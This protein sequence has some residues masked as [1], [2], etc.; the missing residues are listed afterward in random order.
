MTYFLYWIGIFILAFSICAIIKV[1]QCEDSELPFNKEHVFKV[2]TILIALGSIFIG[3][4]L[5]F[6]NSEKSKEVNLKFIQNNN[7][8]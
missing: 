3:V 6:L 4:T 8:K 2:I 7:I 1:E 5:P